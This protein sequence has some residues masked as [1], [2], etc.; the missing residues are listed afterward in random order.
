MR[1]FS[2]NVV[3]R[4]LYQETILPNLAYVGGP[5]EIAYWLQFKAVFDYF[6]VSYPILVPRASGLLISKNLQAK[7]KNLGLNPTSLILN[8]A[9]LKE[10]FIGNQ[11]DQALNFDG[12]DETL[13]L[14]YQNFQ[15]QIEQVD[16]QLL[17]YFQKQKHQINQIIRGLKKRL[18]SRNEAKHAADLAKIDQL[19]TKLFPNEQP[20]ERHENFLSFY[21]N[22]PNLIAD[23]YHLIEPFEQ[24]Y[25]VVDL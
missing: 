16:P 11:V 18:T 5:S 2:P 23:L 21:I 4:P 6:K 14:L 12:A 25:Y 17:G 22:N 24:A 8:R 15:T 10:E 1:N 19:K 9:G 3:L 7:I 13:N 20:Q